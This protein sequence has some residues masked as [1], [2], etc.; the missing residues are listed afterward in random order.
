MA[1]LL[2][3]EHDNKTLAPA[4]AKALAAAQEFG[5]E[6]DILVAGENAGAVAEAAAKLAGVRKV[7]L[8]EAPQLNAAPCR[9]DC[10]SRSCR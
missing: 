10:Q 7:L 1:V 6:V 5:G 3:A 4:T 8:A 9:R 2:L